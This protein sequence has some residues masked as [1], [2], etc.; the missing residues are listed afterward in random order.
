MVMTEPAQVQTE[1]P[2]SRLSTKSSAAAARRISHAPI[3]ASNARGIGSGDHAPD[4]A[5]YP[6]GGAGAH[7]ARHQRLRLRLRRPVPSR[8]D[9]LQ[10]P[11]KAPSVRYVRFACKLSILSAS[12]ICW[13]Q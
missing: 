2:R 13:A 7:E 3:T 10:E 1:S 11:L 5:S 8:P 9:L 12:L 4:R 6:C